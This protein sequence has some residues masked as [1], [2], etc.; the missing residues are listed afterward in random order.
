M[1]GL[2]RI[3]DDTICGSCRRFFENVKRETVES[4]ESRRS[5]NTEE[6]LSLLRK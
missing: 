3:D 4:L 2:T 5:I 1:R 6:L